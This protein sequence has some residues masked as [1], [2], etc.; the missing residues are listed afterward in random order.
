M[1]DMGKVMG[2]VTPKVKGRYDMSEVSRKIKEKL[3]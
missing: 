3:S 2:I 1:R